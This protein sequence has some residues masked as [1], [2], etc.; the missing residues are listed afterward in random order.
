MENYIIDSVFE[1]PI[2][3][4]LIEHVVYLAKGQA[5]VIATQENMRVQLEETQ[6]LQLPFLFPQDGYL[7]GKLFLII[8]LYNL[9]FFCK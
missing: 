4:D 7:I 3:V 9:I 8:L 6:Q 5:D 1:Q 2:S